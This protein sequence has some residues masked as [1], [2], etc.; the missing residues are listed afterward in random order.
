MA[1]I[2]ART[3]VDGTTT[4]RVGYRHDHG[5]GRK[6]HWTGAFETADGAVEAKN[7][8]ERMGPELALATLDTRNR[9]VEDRP[10]LVS[11]MLET[12]LTSLGA[13]ATVGTVDD[14]RRM[15]A[16]TWLTRL[17]PLPLDALER[18]HVVEWVRWQRA[19]ETARSIAARKKA[20]ESGLTEPP[21]R[22][23]APKSIVNAQGLLSDV[24]DAAVEAG[25]IPRNVASAVQIAHDAEP[26]EMIMLTSSEFAKLLVQIPPHWQPL[27][28]FLAGTGARWGEATALRS[29]DFDLEDER[30]YVRI[31]RAWKKG[32]RGTSYIGSPKTRRGVRTVTL[33]A[34]VAEMV[35]P[36]VEAARADGGLVFRGDRG[37][38]PHHSH[39]YARVWQPA[40]VRASLGKTPRVHDLRHSHVSWLLAR[41]VILPVIQRR[42][43]HES[44]TTTV[45]RYG[46]L[47]A[48][49][50]AGAADATEDA[51]GLALPAVELPQI[52]T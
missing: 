24:L 11:E 43:G 50:H 51:L 28:S 8:I 12:H 45:D 39:F 17:G 38:N 23:Y 7:M 13:H 14:Y 32:V 30:P 21:P 41:N 3:R 25:H 16:R 26:E 42:L 35:R 34:G 18:E 44:I 37:G 6:L 47:A 19:Q 46:H 4:Y 29:S 40:V 10:P 48:D 15:A 5:D 31:S 33:S 9:E 2:Q 1:Q 49:A 36:R 22:T 52:E 20:R 27:V